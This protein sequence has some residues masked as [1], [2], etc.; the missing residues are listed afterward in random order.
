MEIFYK[1]ES[2]SHSYDNNKHYI[3]YYYSCSNEEY[4]TIK[5]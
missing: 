3:D 5:E 2:E 1:T 4:N